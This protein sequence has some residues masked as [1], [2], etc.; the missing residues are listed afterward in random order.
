MN[1]R[2]DRLRER[3]NR[4]ARER[5]MPMQVTGIG[6]IFAVHFHRG[7][8]RNAGDIERAEA[9]REAEIRQLKTLFHLDLLAA[10]QYLSRR[11]LCNLSLET[12][13][14]DLD[15]LCGAVEEFLSSRGG[16]LREAAADR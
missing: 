8:I 10:G 4:M 1:R 2:G 5:D 15:G 11:L 16:L 9:G 12:S 3:L 6:S 13:E 7:P 14:G